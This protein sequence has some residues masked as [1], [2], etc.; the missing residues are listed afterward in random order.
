MPGEKIQQTIGDLD[1]R[2]AMLYDFRARLTHMK[3]DLAVLLES[4]PREMPV[5]P[6]PGL[7]Q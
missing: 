4:I 5:N 7:K 3:R 1:D 2:Q 6:Q